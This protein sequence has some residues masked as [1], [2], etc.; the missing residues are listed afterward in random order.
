MPAKDTYHQAVKTALIHDGWLI[1]HD[2]LR[3]RLARG[4]NLFV[5]LGAERLIGA[6]RGGEKIAVEIKSFKRASDM[7]DLEEALGQYVLYE[8]LLLRHATDR[9]LYLA[10]TEEVRKSVFEEEAGQVLLEDGIL[11][12]VTFDPIKEVIVRWITP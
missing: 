5:D 8:R 4:K 2:P 3:L 11:R 10:V 1:T 6:E 7:K 9:T 12:L